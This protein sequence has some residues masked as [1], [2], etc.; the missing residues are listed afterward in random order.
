[1]EQD[2]TLL[3][4]KRAKLRIQ[5]EHPFFSDI[6]FFTKLEES[7][8]V[9]TMGVMPDGN[10]LYNK[11]W[12]EGL[13]PKQ[14]EG[15]LCHE[16][17][18]LAFMHTLRGIKKPNHGVWNLAIDCHANFIPKK[19]GMELPRDGACVPDV[20]H[21]SV[22]I[23]GE[24]GRSLYEVERVEEK[25]SEQIYNELMSNLPNDIKQSLDKKVKIKMLGDG[26]MQIKTSQGSFDVHIYG[27]SKDS[28]PAKVKKSEQEWTQ[29]LINA[30]ERA[31]KIG[32]LP[33]GMERL[34]GKLLEPKVSWRHRLYRFITDG[35]PFDYTYRRRDKR[36]SALGWYIPSYEKEALEVAVFIDTSGSISDKEISEFK[37]EC[38]SIA[39]SFETV[40]MTLAY[41]DTK[42]YEPL[43]VEN[44]NVDL[45]MESKPKGG[46]GTDMT[47]IF[48]WLDTNMP[49]ANVVVILTDGYTPW[50]TAN[51]VGTRNVLWVISTNGASKDN[52][53]KNIGEFVPLKEE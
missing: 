38:V 32:K 34:L 5:K 8:E 10:I 43:L 22:Q 35:M 33:G 24:G 21:G 42:V 39:K 4:I 27:N 41:C 9:P 53:G 3:K 16:V 47:A 31:K 17:L 15:V 19:N 25:S 11:S 46:G 2:K 30:S 40:D 18:H 52:F 44:G 29:R 23:K 28:T 14:L 48:P 26:K 13:T 49:N 6:L 51:Q 45:I 36:S 50:P 7:E 20:Y 12:I 37:S 1:M